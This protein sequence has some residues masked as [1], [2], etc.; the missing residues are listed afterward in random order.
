MLTH[1]W[2]KEWIF[3]PSS[4]CQIWFM[5]SRTI[6]QTWF[7]FLFCLFQKLPIHSD[8]LV[9]PVSIDSQWKFIAHLNFHPPL[10][11]NI[12]SIKS[13][14]QWFMMN[15]GEEL[16]LTTGPCRALKMR[17]ETWAPHFIPDVTQQ[18]AWKTGV[19]HSWDVHCPVLGSHPNWWQE[20]F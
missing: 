9:M 10:Y 17:A 3:F 1:Q 4:T 6:S 8:S 7:R 18:G 16:L 12:V 20:F 15:Q 2:K 5:I 13:R 19:R 14:C 11:S